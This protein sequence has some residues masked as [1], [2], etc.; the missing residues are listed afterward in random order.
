MR[1]LSLL[2]FVSSQAFAAGIVNVGGYTRSNG[3]YVAPHVRT[4][5]D[6]TDTNN[7]GSLYNGNSHNNNDNSIYKQPSAFKNSFGNPYDND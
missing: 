7:Y 1:L 5:P 4:A 2:I 6:T 3:T